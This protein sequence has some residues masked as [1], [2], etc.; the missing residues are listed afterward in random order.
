MIKILFSTVLFASILNANAFLFGNNEWDDLR[1]TWGINPLASNSYNKLPRNLDDAKSQ[2][3]VLEKDCSQVNGNRYIL[4]NDPAVLLI[5]DNKGT[6][7][8]IASKISNNLPFNMPSK[9][10]Q[11]YFT[12]EGDSY[13]ISAYFT[14][15]NLVC[16]NV[17]RRVSTGDRLV[18]KGDKQTLNIPLIEENVLSETFFTKGGCFYTMGQHYWANLKGIQ[19]DED[20]PIEHFLPIFLL[21]NKGQLN[22]F[23]WAFNAILESPRYERPPI[24]AIGKFFQTN[25][26]A[27]FKDP[28][29]SNGISTMH[30]YLDSTPLLNFC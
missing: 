5:F 30:I 22:G 21:Y 4:N 15:P 10:Q 3:W 13:V 12:N 20:I 2:G 24:D 16:S 23:G 26:P 9:E 11:E 28:K 17:I 29:K 25:P 8:G 14:D 1:V 27:A 19:V 6:I 7:A 18:I